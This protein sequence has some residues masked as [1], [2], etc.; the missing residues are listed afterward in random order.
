MYPNSWHVANGLSEIAPG[1]AVVLQASTGNLYIDGNVFPG[2]TDFA[3]M[4]ETV[5]G[6]PIHPG[7]FG[8]LSGEKVRIA[9]AN[10]KCILGIVSAT[11]AI[12]G[13]SAELH[14]ENK[15]VKD[16]WG[17]IQYEQITIE[18]KKMPQAR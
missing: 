12:T 7:Y 6:K 16:K 4:F 3:E 9:N 10:D 2:G 1:L 14:W 15:F 18:E 17:I 13:D 8:T 5:D 11:P